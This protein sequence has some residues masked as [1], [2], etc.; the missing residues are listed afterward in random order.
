MKDKTFVR[1]VADHF[2]CDDRRAE[3]LIFAVFQALRDRT[4]PAE[5]ADVAAL[6]SLPR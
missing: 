5:A 2:G 4:T 1:D 3:M 6:N